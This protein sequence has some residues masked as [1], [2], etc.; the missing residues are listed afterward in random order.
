MTISLDTYASKGE[1]RVARKLVR[2]ALESGYSL[3]IHDGEEW[4]VRRSKDADAILAALATT[5]MDSIRFRSPEGPRVGELVLVWGNDPEGRELVADIQ[6]P[7]ELD[8]IELES[9]VK[10]VLG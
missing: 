8:L 4:T 2:A 3:S 6:A 1:A 9:F 10:R 7:W 5:G